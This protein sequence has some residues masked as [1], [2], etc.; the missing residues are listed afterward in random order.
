MKR[1]LVLIALL[2]GIAPL[3]HAQQATLTAPINVTVPTG[4]TQVVQATHAIVTDVQESRDSANVTIVVAQRDS[5]GNVLRRLSIVIPD[6][7]SSCPTATVQGFENARSTARSG[8]Q[9]NA[10]ARTQNFRVL[11]YLLDQGC[12]SGVTLV[13]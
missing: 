2:L 6:A 12:I 8:E 5:G 4:T 11:G 1:V 3:A 9:A 7:G 10:G 13:P